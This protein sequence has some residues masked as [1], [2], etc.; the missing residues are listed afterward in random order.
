[1]RSIMLQFLWWTLWSPTM[2]KFFLSPKTLLL[3]YTR[4]VP[5]SNSTVM[6]TRSSII[7]LMQILY[8]E[9]VF[10]IELFTKS[11]NIPT[12]LS[13]QKN[14]F[15]FLYDTIYRWDS[16]E[17]LTNSSSKFVINKLWYHLSHPH[18]VPTRILRSC[19]SWGRETPWCF[20]LAFLATPSM[21]HS[22]YTSSCIS[23]PYFILG[24]GWVTLLL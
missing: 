13:P 7:S 5:R 12:E 18:S 24:Y 15:I 8:D 10:P 16:G 23:Y 2:S 4:C 19:T 6:P 14:A 17:Y 11:T 3:V 22:N 9:H 1:M 20:S 21:G